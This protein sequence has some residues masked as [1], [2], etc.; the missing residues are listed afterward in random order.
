MLLGKCFSCGWNRRKSLA[1]ALE[2]SISFCDGVLY[3]KMGK[4]MFECCVETMGKEST[5]REK[6]Q[7]NHSRGDR[8]NEKRNDCIRV[9]DNIIRSRERELYIHNALLLLFFFFLSNTLRC[10]CTIITFLNHYAMNLNLSR[11][12]TVTLKRGLP[13]DVPPQNMHRNGK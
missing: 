3:V 11:S 7:C 5:T 4:C 10:S 2:L 8:L 12:I 9:C 1:L 6:Y 13:F